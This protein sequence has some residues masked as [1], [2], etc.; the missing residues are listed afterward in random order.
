MALT[1]VQIASQALVRLGAPPIS[2]F[3]APTLEA[4]T[5]AALYPTLRDTLI[6]GHA[7]RFATAEAELSPAEEPPLDGFAH[8][9][10]LP[11][12]FLNALAVGR[13]RETDWR[14]S[15]G[16][17]H[18]HPAALRLA[19]IFRADEAEFPSWFADALAAGLA[20]AFCLPVTEN[21]S[22]AEALARLADAALRRAR[23]IDTLHDPAR[24][25]LR[26]PLVEARA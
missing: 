9:F 18:A 10:R 11:A 16:M 3:A 22:R 20:A 24:A 5:A 21:T 17:L 15:G 26:F 25:P 13:G 6:A 14:I 7:W 1:A 8:A 23:R 2:D 19:Y 12:G 4:R